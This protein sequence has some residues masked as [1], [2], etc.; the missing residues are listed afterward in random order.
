MES[1]KPARGW[2]GGFRRTAVFRGS[3]S[4]RGARGDA[5][6]GTAERSC[7]P[8]ARSRRGAGQGVMENGEHLPK[9]AKPQAVEGC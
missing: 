1:C 3:C 8:A 2:L 5:E 6:E 4:S 7:V 9:A